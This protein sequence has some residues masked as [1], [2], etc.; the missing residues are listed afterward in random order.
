MYVVS[1]SDKDCLPGEEDAD[2]AV[3]RHDGRLQLVTHKLGEGLREPLGSDAVMLRAVELTTAIG[4][5]PGYPVAIALSPDGVEVRDRVV[6]ARG[7]MFS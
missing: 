2:V 5:G 4:G 1:Q 7:A 6:Q 3:L